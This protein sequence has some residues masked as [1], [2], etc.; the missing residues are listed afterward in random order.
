MVESRGTL[1]LLDL[2]TSEANKNMET[3]A[4]HGEFHMVSIN[5][6]IPKWMVYFMENPIKID[7]KRGTRHAKT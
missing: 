5:M 7:D 3:S 1:G 6:R 2:L 4:K